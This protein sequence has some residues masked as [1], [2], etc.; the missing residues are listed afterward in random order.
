MTKK[1]GTDRFWANLPPS[2]DMDTEICMRNLV[3]DR[4]TMA[5]APNTVFAEMIV[6]SL[7]LQFPTWVDMEK[8]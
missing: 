7:N 3:G 2:F 6:D 8:Q 5:I 4:M 1:Y